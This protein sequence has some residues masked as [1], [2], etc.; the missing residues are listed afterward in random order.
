MLS[1]HK[2]YEMKRKRTLTKKV[3]G[4]ILLLILVGTIQHLVLTLHYDMRISELD[5]RI[6]VLEE[7]VDEKDKKIE[8]MVSDIKLMIDVSRT[9]EQLYGS[10]EL[11]I[12]EA[13]EIDNNTKVGE[14]FLI[15][16]YVLERSSGYAIADGNIES[17][18]GEL[19][20]VLVK[21]DKE[22]METLEEYLGNNWSKPI[23]VYG[24]VADC[25]GTVCLEIIRW[26][27][28]YEVLMEEN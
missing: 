2:I 16:G 4:V 19:R 20:S 25:N 1:K 9:Y 10:L 24:V 8:D 23:L 14:K 17:E 11:T 5:E 28:P 18:E 22:I 21:P 6:A 15:R 13:N 7:E 27:A 26:S 3:L 12:R